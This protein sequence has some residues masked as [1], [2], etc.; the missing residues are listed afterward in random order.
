[1]FCQKKERSKAR[2]KGI[3][4]FSEK[5][6]KLKIIQYEGKQ[7]KKCEK[8]NVKSARIYFVPSKNECRRK[9]SHQRIRGE[10]AKNE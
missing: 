9:D 1:V 5:V 4:R 8:L 2:A 6:I 7:Q 10:E 3:K